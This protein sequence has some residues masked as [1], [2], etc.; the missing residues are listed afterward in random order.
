MVIT[1]VNQVVYQGDGTNTAWPFTF[2]IID[3]TDI[4]LLLI[5]V[6]GTET[7]IATDYFVDTVNSTVHYPGYAPGAEPPEADQPAPVQTG[8]RLVI[9]R[10]LP[11]TQEKD[12]GDKWP[13]S[14]IE[15]ALDKLTMILQQI[16]GWWGRT[17]KFPVGWQIDHP[18]FDTSIPVEA[19]KT[20][21]V[22]DAGTGF[23]AS[24]SSEE[25]MAV[26]Q[27]AKDTADAAAL[28][29]GGAVS[30]ANDAKNTAE[31]IAGTAQSAL[32]T[33]N[34]AKETADGIA[35]TAQS[36]VDLATQ[37]VDD[38]ADAVD[39]VEALET[40]VI[41]NTENIT[42]LLKS[43]LWYDNVAT[44]VADT[45]LEAGN[46]AVTKGF[47]SA[48]D[49]GKS[50]YLIRAKTN[51]DT[52]D[53]WSLLQLATNTLVAELYVP[54][55]MLNVKQCG[56]YGDNSTD[57]Y[58]Y[59][60]YALL[61]SKYKTILFPPGTYA[62]SG[63]LNVKEGFHLIGH[64]AILRK[65]DPST[66]FLELGERNI[67]VENLR[68][69]RDVQRVRGNTTS[70]I[71][72]HSTTGADISNI[73]VTNCIIC[74]A[75]MYGVNIQDSSHYVRGVFVDHCKIYNVAVGVKNGGGY[76]RSVVIDSCTISDTLGECVTFDGTVQY[77]KL[78]N[79]TLYNNDA[80]VGLVG[81]DQ[82]SF[83]TIAN[84]T[85]TQ[86][87]NPTTSTSLKKGITFNRHMGICNGYT[88]ANNVFVSCV[89]GVQCKKAETDSQGTWVYNG[90]KNLVCSNNVFIDSINADIQIDNIEGTNRI[91]NNVL[92]SAGIV[93]DEA[94]I[95]N[96]RKTTTFLTGVS[97]PKDVP[98][99]T[100][101]D[102]MRRLM[103]SDTHLNIKLIG[104][105]I[106]Q[107]A[108]GT[109]LDSAG[110]LIFG[111][112]HVNVGGHCWANT[113][114]AYFE[115]HFNCTVNNYGCGGITSGVA[116]QNISSLIKATD[117]IVI[118]M[119][120]TNDR[121]NTT[122]PISGS[123][124]STTTLYNNLLTIY[125]YC[126]ERGIDIIFMSSVPAS[127]T[128]EQNN[129]TFHMN[130]VDH[131]IMKLASDWNMEYISVYKLFSRYIVSQ[132]FT[133]DDV[134]TDG[135]H[136][137]DTGYDI[138]NYLITDALGF[139]N[140]LNAVEGQPTLI[141]EEAVTLTPESNV[142]TLYYNG[143][144]IGKYVVVTLR[145]RFASIDAQGWTK[146]CTSNILPQTTAYFHFV[147]A[148][149]TTI[150]DGE[151][152]RSIGGFRIWVTTA[153]EN[154]DISGT[155]VAKVE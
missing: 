152:N 55:G 3:A 33:A 56:A 35:A 61:N 82:S 89:V 64:D 112:H 115:N 88:I 28:A 151:F 46:V 21:R 133:L 100:I 48:G 86:V 121:I 59:V 91:A 65:T 109:G 4:K 97:Q 1:D 90:V 12:L 147:S 63:R 131:T 103:L 30:T 124:Q 134:L 8:Q 51:A 73:R 96:I 99:K 20:W 142:Q 76:T 122:D 101:K 110:T 29:A 47:Y 40:Q 102:T 106:T 105:S 132:G 53:T 148:S 127:Q 138:M 26:A 130:D 78:T 129:K 137:N 123:T 37:A 19:G 36:A 24:N 38:A 44:L 94:N 10:E 141:S 13:F 25:A 81:C 17:L 79:C 32:D 93:L 68:I 58:T 136:P 67:T 15:L 6:D 23:V 80:G 72:I 111:T 149:S 54:D 150:R 27:S 145:F 62:I 16:Y 113:L 9:Y 42:E 69:T 92:S 139:G 18:D 11:I 39:T 14:I 98:V 143:F 128:N 5:D 146:I 120:G 135:L 70:L 126:R 116:V 66:S 45:K 57:D 49:G 52:T 75:D 22:N 154:K 140:S 74:D 2:R 77:S 43:A 34:D 31:G 104:D 114:K 118:C 155:V 108:G 50:I 107:G 153:D 60:R 7:D 84:N 83:I 87:G 41:T 119:L 144:K 95:K 117:D 85:F 125:Q 71:L